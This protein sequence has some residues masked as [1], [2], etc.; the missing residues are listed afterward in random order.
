LG[1]G[2]GV[3]PE[4]EGAPLLGVQAPPQRSCSCMPAAACGLRVLHSIMCGV[5]ACTVCGT[6][7]AVPLDGQAH[8]CSRVARWSLGMQALGACARSERRSRRLG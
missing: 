2:P 1:R 4:A 8:T 3:G 7:F 5:V 6:P